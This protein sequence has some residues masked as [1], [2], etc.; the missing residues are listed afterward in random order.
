M[1]KRG[2]SSSFATPEYK[3]QKIFYLRTYEAEDILIDLS[4]FPENT[5]LQKAIES[6]QPKIFEEGSLF[7]SEE[8]SHDFLEVPKNS[9]LFKLKSGT[10][11][12]PV[13]K[14]RIFHNQQ[15]LIPRLFTGYE[16]AQYIKIKYFPKSSSTPIFKID[17]KTIDMKS[18]LQQ[19]NIKDNHQITFLTSDEDELDEEDNQENV[20]SEDNN[21]LSC[22]D[23][24]S[25]ASGQ[26]IKYQISSF[27]TFSKLIESEKL[28]QSLQDFLTKN[29]FTL[30][31]ADDF[32][33]CYLDSRG[34]IFPV[35]STSQTVD[36]IPEPKT[37]LWR[38]KYCSEIFQQK[39]DQYIREGSSE[40]LTF[41]GETLCVVNEPEKK[42]FYPI[43]Q[44]YKLIDPDDNEIIS[45]IK[46]LINHL[47]TK[48]QM[49]MVPSEY[50]RI[51]NFLQKHYETLPYVD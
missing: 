7:A 23:Y 3:K 48:A 16:L 5:T 40:C 49:F 38:Y 41:L 37:L 30:T 39:L 24:I 10:V 4:I 45:K 18:P 20:E 32:E 47:L 9:F 22:F 25:P 21:N 1:V 36:Q 51:H 2:C 42:V 26:K 34:T 35:P 14:L 28:G 31:T 43:Y 17:N 44:E 13:Y 19:Q 27:V 50:N 11:V 8:D 15:L 29:K 6:I 12:I 46:G 33:L